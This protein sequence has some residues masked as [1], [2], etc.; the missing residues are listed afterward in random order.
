MSG[1]YGSGKTHLF[2]AQY[3]EIAIAGKTL[4]HVR[5]TRELLEE[6]KKMELSNDFVSPVMAAAYSRAVSIGDKKAGNWLPAG[7]DPHSGLG[8]MPV[9]KSAI[10]RIVRMS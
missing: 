6:L 9:I 2:Y 5:T 10:L 7:E 8:K 4:C 3:R 1:P